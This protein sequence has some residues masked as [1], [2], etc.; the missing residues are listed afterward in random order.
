MVPGSRRKLDG[1]LAVR[2]L[3]P[4]SRELP[5]PGR[6]RTGVAGAAG[7]AGV[8]RRDISGPVSGQLAPAPSIRDIFL[9]P[10]VASK[11]LIAYMQL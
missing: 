7:A 10:I 1:W 4:A 6:A 11:R 9:L 3:V 5:L 8:A 2:T